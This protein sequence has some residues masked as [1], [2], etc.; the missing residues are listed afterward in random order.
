MLS[1][2][3]RPPMPTN[4]RYLHVHPGTAASTTQR[5]R[6]AFRCIMRPKDGE[7]DGHQRKVPC[8]MGGGGKQHFLPAALIAGFGTSQQ[9]D[10]CVKPR[11]LWRLQDWQQS[12]PAAAESIEHVNKMYRLAAPPPGV[13]AGHEGVSQSGCCSRP[14]AGRP[15]VRIGYKGRCTGRKGK[16]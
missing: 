12:R 5:S 9:G 16:Q 8:L 11:W 6:D 15:E 4:A 13:S 14:S 10:A 1:A 7:P 3:D 2:D